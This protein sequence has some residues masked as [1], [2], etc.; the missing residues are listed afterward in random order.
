MKY[1]LCSLLNLKV[2]FKMFFFQ[3]LQDVLTNLYNSETSTAYI[4]INLMDTIKQ[5]LKNLLLLNSFDYNII[6]KILQDKSWNDEKIK[7]FLILIEENKNRLLYD[8]LI[9][10]N[11]S[12]CESVMD[13][14]WNVKLVLG[15]S[16]LK[17]IKYPLL[18][19]MF[20][21]RTLSGQED[22]FGCELNKNMLE[23]VIDLLES[24][25]KYN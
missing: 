3:V 21:T 14:D 19:L 13:F 18:H 10:H 22:I 7:I 12:Y 4:N 5:D 23:K 6:T 11:S 8:T 24:C 25:A 2:F 15:S 9:S 1:W 20:S 16:E 17:S